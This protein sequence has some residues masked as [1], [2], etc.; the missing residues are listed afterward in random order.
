MGMTARVT[1]SMTLAGLCAA[2][3]A[4]PRPRLMIATDISPPSVMMDKGRLAGI[5]TDK[6]REIMK[7]V[8]VDAGIEILPFK[9]AY[10]HGQTRAD[11]CLFPLM[12]L[13]ERER[14]FKWVGPTHESDWTLFGRAGRDYGVHR[15]EDARKY[16]I[17]AYFGDVR[18][19]TLAAQGFK[20]DT[21]RERLAN[22]RKL[23]V[24]RI[25]L[26]T[27]SLEAGDKIIAENGWKTQ[28]VPVFTFKRPTNYLACNP[29]VPD[30]LIAKMNAALRAMN[31]DGVSSAIERRYKAP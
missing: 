4:A 7:R 13:P 17:G 6:V 5:T 31:S 16:R 10:L 14:L 8:G 21:T 25:D 15:L 19:E 27:A 1:L 20:V 23:L 26:W 24:D 18:G 11:A 2:A 28:I 3:G 12:R 29:G 9:R 30:D 22:P